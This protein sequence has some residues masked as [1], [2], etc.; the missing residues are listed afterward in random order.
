MNDRTRVENGFR[1]N[2]SRDGSFSPHLGVKVSDRI[3]KYCKRHNQ[4]RTRF[5]EQ[6]C[7]EAL[8]RLEHEELENMS[9]EELIKMISDRLFA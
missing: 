1:K 4:N 8:N 9:K 6:I 2:E 5:V 3:T 7:I